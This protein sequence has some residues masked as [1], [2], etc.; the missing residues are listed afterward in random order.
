MP[1]IPS[2]LCEEDWSGPRPPDCMLMV[3]RRCWLSTC[4]LLLP[5]WPPA[6]ESG[7]SC[8]WP[9]P[10]DSLWP[11]AGALVGMS[12]CRSMAWWCHSSSL[13]LG[14]PGQSVSTWV[15]VW[16]LPE[17]AWHFPVLIS[18]LSNPLFQI[19]PCGV[20]PFIP[21]CP[22]LPWHQR[23]SRYQVDWVTGHPGVRQAY[24][25]SWRQ[26]WEHPPWWVAS[27]NVGWLS[28]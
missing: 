27:L 18:C 15:I 19:S 8:G 23:F 12:C 17:L 1:S 2:H 25:Q 3:G 21:V 10:R 5:T 20:W 6:V 13:V 22:E 7:L 16:T 4:C 11:G 26:E 9:L 14:K 24:H 28:P